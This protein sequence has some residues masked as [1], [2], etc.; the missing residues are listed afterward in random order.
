M[1]IAI[2]AT[3]N[4]GSENSPKENYIGMGVLSSI[5]HKGQE[6]SNPNFPDDADHVV[7]VIEVDKNEERTKVTRQCS[8][9]FEWTRKERTERRNIFEKSK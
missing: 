6:G 8:C 7:T 3:Y 1:N 9:G 5:N 4:L 2:G